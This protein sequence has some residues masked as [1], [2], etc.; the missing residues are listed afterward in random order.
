MKE[1]EDGTEAMVW[2]GGGG[3]MER[4]AFLWF[5]ISQL[6]PWDLEV[7]PGG[8]ATPDRP[9]PC[10]AV[11]CLRNRELSESTAEQVEISASCAKNKSM[12]K[13]DLM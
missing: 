6:P 3:V 4:P 9:G 13:N 7:P 2:V 11:G 12:G 10:W 1:E 8:E 5:G